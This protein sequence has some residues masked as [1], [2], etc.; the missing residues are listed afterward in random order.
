M[1]DDVFLPLL[2]GPDDQ[3]VSP[4]HVTD[5]FLG[6][7]RVAY[8]TGPEFGQHLL[9]WEELERLRLPRPELRRAAATQLYH[10]LDQVG[11]HGQ[12]PALMLSFE[13]LEASVVLAHRF[14]DD[15]EGSVPGELVVGVPVRD[16]VIFTGSESPSGM[17]R[18]R[19]A[20]DRM[21]FAGCPHPVS[22][23]LLVRR[24]RRWQVLRVAGDEFSGPP[25]V[26]EAPVSP[27]V[28]GDLPG[29]PVSPPVA[30]PVPMSPAAPMSPVPMSPAAS[31]SP[32]PISPVPQIYPRKPISSVRGR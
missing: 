17:R 13:G 20:V 21:F 4:A 16:M 5:P 27:A 9:T 26:Q 15:L 18:V 11:I 6:D 30:R 19:R 14:W 8:T 29:S 7:L 31:T 22:Q 28:P 23:D 2:A 32:M 10:L 3:Q 12:P 25:V 24:E 1:T